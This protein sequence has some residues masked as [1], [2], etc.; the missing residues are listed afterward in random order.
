MSTATLIIRTGLQGHGKTLNTIKE[1]DT[2]AFKEGRPVYFH[3]I[4]DL[5]PSKLK[6]DW[7][8]FDD[9]HKWYELPNDSIIVVDE[10]QGFFPVRDPRKEVPEYASRFEIMRK[11]G[12]EVHLITQDPR[13]IDVH[14]RRLCGSHIHYNRVWGS[15]NVARYQTERVFNEVE[16]FAGNK[17]ADR[18]IIKLDKNYFGVYSSAQ[19]QHHFKFKPSRKAIFFAFAAV[20]TVWLCIR[21]F[22]L[23]YG[24]Q[25]ET[26]SSELASAAAAVASS[27]FGALLDG[28]T[29]IEGKP[30]T[31]AEYLSSYEPRIPDIPASAPVY[32]S[33]TQPQSHPRLYCISSTDKNLLARS[34]APWAIDDGNPTACQCYTQQGTR[35]ST[36]FD[37]CLNAVKRGYFDNTRPDRMT[38]QMQQPGQ[39][40]PASSQQIARHIPPGQ[41]NPDTARQI[42][43]IPY[44]KGQFLW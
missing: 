41:Q 29:Q 26:E 22:N 36:T 18:T 17:T 10:A 37:F 6:A 24:E 25:P 34:D 14:V 16:K 35:V 3:N 31:R 42:V 32:D 30:R 27:P 43:I 2:K 28:P 20:V 11:Q 9:P 19:A 4:T 21:V 15:S 13:F 8:P 12:H 40:P 39:L 33:L 38:V 1:V 23:F 44:E 7:F 5:E